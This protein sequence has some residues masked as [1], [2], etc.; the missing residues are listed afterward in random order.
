MK[1]TNNMTDVLDCLLAGLSRV[2]ELKFLSLMGMTFPTDSGYEE[3]N[4]LYETQQSLIYDLFN[5]NIKQSNFN[6]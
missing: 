2:T 4:E 5:N 3:L 1:T 6:E